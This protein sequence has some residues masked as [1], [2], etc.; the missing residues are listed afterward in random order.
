[1]IWGARL[2]GL[3]GRIPLSGV[4]IALVGFLF[5]WLLGNTVGESYGRKVG[6]ILCDVELA[7]H[8]AEVA[9]DAAR[10]LME[11]ENVADSEYRDAGG[12]HDRLCATD[13]HCRD[14]G[15]GVPVDAPDQL[16]AGGHGGNGEANSPTQRGPQSALQAGGG[17]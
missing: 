17:R 7:K 8:N 13:E 5:G 9:M 6:A 10:I 1:M 16:D 15:R 11:A 3:L 4:L 12:D 2:M 14:D